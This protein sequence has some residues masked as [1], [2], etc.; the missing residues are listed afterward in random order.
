MV[1]SPLSTM[2][3]MVTIGDELPGHKRHEY[4]DMLGLRFTVM[5]ATDLAL[6]VWKKQR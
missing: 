5:V 2:T 4:E 6:R 3:L 1:M